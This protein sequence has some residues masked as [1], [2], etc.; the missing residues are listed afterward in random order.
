MLALPV[1]PHHTPPLLEAHWAAQLL[2]T[3]PLIGP[4]SRPDTPHGPWP[5]KSVCKP[6]LVPRP[7]LGVRYT[8]HTLIPPLQL[9]GQGSHRVLP[10]AFRFPATP[11]AGLTAKS[12]G[13]CACGRSE[14]CRGGCIKRPLRGL[15]FL[16]PLVTTPNPFTTGLGY[17]LPP[18]GRFPFF[19]FTEVTL[20]HALSDLSHQRHHD[21]LIVS[22]IASYNLRSDSG[23]WSA[24]AATLISRP[25]S[26]RTSRQP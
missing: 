15:S 9:A 5:V 1:P 14:L 18:H 4:N 13:V 25:K 10:C 26:H 8:L 24:P 12:S 7:S 22:A 19:F 6:C 17:I 23:E 11:G 21:D 2:L 3:P 16:A 20:P